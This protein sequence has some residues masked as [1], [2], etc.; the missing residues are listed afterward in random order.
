MHKC[1]STSS[2]I[3]RM[4]G[5]TSLEAQPRNMK[6][7]A[8]NVAQASILAANLARSTLHEVNATARRSL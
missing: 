2:A 3:A 4:P 8:V 1:L 7:L 6:V 5:V